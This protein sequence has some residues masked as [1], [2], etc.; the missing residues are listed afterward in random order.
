MRSL[1]RAR[2]YGCELQPAPP[3]APTH[4]GRSNG[5][6]TRQRREI[7]HVSGAVRCSPLDGRP[8]WAGGTGQRLT[9]ARSRPW[10]FSA[11]HGW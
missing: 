9:E 10:P 11:W 3:P 8:T 1:P 4:A 2:Q 7:G 6:T 5:T